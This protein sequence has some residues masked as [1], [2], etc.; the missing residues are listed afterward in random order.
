MGHEGL[1]LTDIEA[2]A[3]NAFGDVYLMFFAREAEDDFGVADGEAGVAEIALELRR[4]FEQAEGIGHDGTAF[5]DLGG[6]FL[7]GELELGNELGVALGLF[8]GIEVF[9]L[10]I[11]DQGEFENGAVVGLADDDR[12]FGQAGQLGGAPAAFAGDE[13][14]VSAAFAHDERLNDALLFDGVGEFA[15]RFSGKILARLERA[16]DDAVQLDAL[17]TLARVGRRGNGF[18]NNG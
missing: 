8:D 15:E 2:V 1:G 4:E 16:G 17:D 12:D 5:A 9:A 11:F 6:D 3:Q 10:E 13:F 7:L 14:Q 18:L